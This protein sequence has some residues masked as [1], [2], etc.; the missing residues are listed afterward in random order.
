MR[1][2][3][4]IVQALLRHR[5]IVTTIDDQAWDGVLMEADERS[6]VLRDALAIVRKPDGAVERTPADGE[7]LLPRNRVAYI[8]RTP[9]TAA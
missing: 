7:V 5:F 3:D 8:Q 2:P 1:R 6:L 9:E 4:R